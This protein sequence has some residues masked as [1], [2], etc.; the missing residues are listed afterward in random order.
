MPQLTT[1][2][3]TLI[4]SSTFVLIGTFFTEDMIGFFDF[5]IDVLSF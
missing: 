3:K 1:L 5:M 4:V 2:E